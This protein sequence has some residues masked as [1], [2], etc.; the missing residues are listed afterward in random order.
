[1]IIFHHRLIF[2]IPSQVMILTNI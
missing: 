2:T 1:M